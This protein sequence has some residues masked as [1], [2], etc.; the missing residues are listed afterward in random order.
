MTQTAT[1]QSDAFH[2]GYGDFKAGLSIEACPHPSLSRDASDW[3]MGWIT[4]RDDV[5]DARFPNTPA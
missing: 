2:D 4:A 5:F 3:R 1:K